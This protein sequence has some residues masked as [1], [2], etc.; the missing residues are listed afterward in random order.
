MY[1]MLTLCLAKIPVNLCMLSSLSSAI[2]SR[3]K[4]LMRRVTDEFIVFEI[5]AGV[6]EKG[7]ETGETEFHLRL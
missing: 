4:D 2:S 7:T 5:F 1:V 6:G 3:S